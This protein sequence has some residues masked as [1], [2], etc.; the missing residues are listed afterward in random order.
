MCYSD[1]VYI[2][3]RWKTTIENNQEYDLSLAYPW[4]YLPDIAYRPNNDTIS[5]RV[6]SVNVNLAGQ[7]NIKKNLRKRIDPNKKQFYIGYH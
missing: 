3:I 4:N 6:T 7:K 1:A 5:E 2:Y